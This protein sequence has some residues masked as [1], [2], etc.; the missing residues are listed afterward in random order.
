MTYEERALLVAIALVLREMNE[1]GEASPRALE[2]LN[3][4]MTAVVMQGIGVRPLAGP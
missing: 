2:V 4:T 1:A 3:E